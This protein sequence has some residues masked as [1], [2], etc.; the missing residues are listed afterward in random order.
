MVVPSLRISI[1]RS[2]IRPRSVRV[3]IP[4]AAPRAKSR[5]ISLS[6]SANCLCIYQSPHIYPNLSIYLSSYPSIS[7]SIY[8]YLS[9]YIY[10]YLSISIYIYLSISVYLSI[11]IY[12]YDGGA[13]APHLDP[14]LAHPAALGASHHPT[15][16]AARQEQV[17][18][19][20]S[21]YPNKLSIYLS[22]NLSISIQI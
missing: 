8:I 10:V 11:Y 13:V 16:G 1:R 4:Q 5:Y 22:I 21:I 19:N 3:T 15:G 2:R 12:L 20:L 14:P 17:S 9:I 18:I 7:I 6:K